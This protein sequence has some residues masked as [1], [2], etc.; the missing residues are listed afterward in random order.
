MGRLQRAV[1]IGVGKGMNKGA[2][3]K[4]QSHEIRGRS[5]MEILR[6]FLRWQ[7]E[8]AGRAMIIKQHPVKRLHVSARRQLQLWPTA[9]EAYSLLIE[10]ELLTHHRD[11]PG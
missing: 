2:A 8:N 4:K 3:E 1:G 7:R 9:P 5:Q 11:G 10:Y 6:K